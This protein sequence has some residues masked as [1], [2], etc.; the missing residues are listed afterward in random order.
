[1]HMIDCMSLYAGKEIDCKHNRVN[2][3]DLMLEL[4]PSHCDDKL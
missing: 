2:F 1:M 4:P 3:K